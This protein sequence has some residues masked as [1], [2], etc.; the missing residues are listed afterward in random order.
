MAAAAEEQGA[1]FSEV[2]PRVHP[3]EL[4]QRPL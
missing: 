2:V 1:C 4:R 3:F